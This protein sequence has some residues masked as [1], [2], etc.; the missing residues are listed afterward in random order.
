MN[1]LLSSLLFIGGGIFAIFRG[2]KGIRE[3][4]L[5]NHVGSQVFTGVSG[6]EG[7]WAVRG[8]KFLVAAGCIMSGMGTLMFIGVSLSMLMSP[9]L[10]NRLAFF[11]SSRPQA[12]PT[13]PITSPTPGTFQNNST[14]A[15]SSS[16]SSLSGILDNAAPQGKAEASGA[17][18]NGNNFGFHEPTSN[19]TAPNKPPADD[20]ASN[21]L[22]SDPIDPDAMREQA[23]AM[24][25]EAEDEFE[26]A[27]QAI[28]RQ[29][30]EQQ[31]MA[32]RNSNP[33]ASFGDLF[34]GSNT[35]PANFAPVKLPVP[36]KPFPTI[37]FDTSRV[38]RSQPIGSPLAQGSFEDP[39]QDN[40][41]LVGAIVRKNQLF[42]GAIQSIQPVYQSGSSYEL[43]QSIGS[44]NGEPTLLLAPAGFAVSGLGVHRGTQV[45]S[46][47]LAFMQVGDSGK[48]LTKTLQSSPLVGNAFGQQ[49]TVHGEGKP[50]VSLFG[51][52][53][54]DKLLAVGIVASPRVRIEKNAGPRTWTTADGKFSV[55]AE[56]VGQDAVTVSLRKADGKTISVKKSLLGATDLKYLAD[57]P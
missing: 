35:P 31:A 15:N 26:R 16:G 37:R 11:K 5:T 48:L 22:P 43:G 47:Q 13:S 36:E 14:P 9:S 49:L 52:F 38:E 3:R 34:G 39:V 25:R 57:Q 51:S 33:P 4:Y 53:D 20:S 46:I 27:R 24:R 45:M 2:R 12:S 23:D 30:L 1:L 7:E 44:E 42:G 28:E 50:I 41:L 55:E 17:T 10:M 54:E 8:G 6:V 40:R 56:L 19:D 18:D 21:I 32:D 29:R